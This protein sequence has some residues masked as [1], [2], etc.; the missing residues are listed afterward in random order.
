MAH[1]IP[2]LEQI[3]DGILRD[4]RNVNPDADITV[5]SDNYVQATGEASA[6]RGLYEYIQWGVNQFFPETADDENVVRHASSYGITQVP[7]TNAV[8]SVLMHGTV[9]ASIPAGT[10]GQVNGIQFQTTEAGEIG[11][12]G[13]AT[14]AA[15]ALVAG[16]T[17]NLAENAPGTLVSA[18]PGIDANV[19]FVQMNGGVEAESIESLLE[20]VE[21]KRQ[22]PE[23]GGNKLDYE[24]WAREVPGV[25]SSWCFPKRRGVGSVD[26]AVLT[27]GQP[28]SDE[29]RAA[30]DA[31]VMTKCGAHVDYMTLAPQFIDVPVTV[32]VV[33][34]E[35]A[36]L[37]DVQAALDSSLADYFST[38]KPGSKVIRSRIGTLTGDVKGVA[39]YTMIEPAANVVTIVDALHIEMPSL[40][41]VTI[42]VDEGE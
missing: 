15:M 14:V 17:G 34:E 40:G 10:V 26:V 16:P 18:P 33:L 22:Q 13:S 20:K 9:G 24:R 3:R 30:V 25:T 23:A 39:D 2:S 1:Q 42:E 41:T 27:D 28:P 19:T 7:A 32:S 4:K 11:A 37:P 38:L 8:G 31:H 29:L 21:E 35:G 36:L 5:D 6:I 12:D